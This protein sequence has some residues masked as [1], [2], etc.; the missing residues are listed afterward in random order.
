[1]K[2]ESC[3]SWHG[4]YGA[5]Q[6][7]MGRSG[8]CRRFGTGLVEASVVLG[9]GETHSTHR[10]CWISA[11]AITAWMWLGPRDGEQHLPR[12]W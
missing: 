3:R 12:T 1:M 9:G 2:G 10:S 11:G 8:Q 5:L 4:S 6:E 7:A